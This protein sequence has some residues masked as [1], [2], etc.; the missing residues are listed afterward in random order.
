MF[1]KSNLTSNAMEKLDSFI[2]EIQKRVSNIINIFGHTDS[3]GTNPYNDRLSESRANTV[4]NYLI[5]SGVSNNEI[6]VNGMG[7]NYPVADNE[8]RSGRA[9]NRRVVIEAE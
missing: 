1:D 5:E 9:K 7:E 3:L 2:A 4:K 6:S 8:T